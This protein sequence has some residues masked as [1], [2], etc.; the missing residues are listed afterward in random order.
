MTDDQVKQI[1]SA[2]H[3]LTSVVAQLIDEQSAG[4]ATLK[5]IHARIENSTAVLVAALDD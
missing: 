1:V 4:N 3:E 2:I 5:D